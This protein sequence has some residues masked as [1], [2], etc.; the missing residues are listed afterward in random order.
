MNTDNEN[1][2][3]TPQEDSIKTPVANSDRE[4]AA[5]TKE[6]SEVTAEEMHPVSAHTPAPRRCDSCRKAP[7]G[8]L[9]CHNW[10]DDIPG[11]YADF[12]I[13]EVQFK[14]TRKGYYRNTTGL[15][16]AKGDLVAV[17]ASPGH[18]IGEITLTGRLVAL[19]MKK[20][21]LKRDAEIKR[22][23]RK[24]KPSDIEKYEEA[25]ARENDTMI[26]ARKIA[27]DLNL[28]MKI[29]DVEY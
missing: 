17:E 22:I 20:A 7:R 29:G 28:N 11:G 21:G 6:Q 16:I 25:K 27:E 3:A 4:S 9:H 14:N 26:K 1:I 10:L 23:F 24:A 5:A 12:D 15:D 18:D 13:V 8:K 19:Q 2:P